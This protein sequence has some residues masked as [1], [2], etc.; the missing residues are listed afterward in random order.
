MIMSRRLLSTVLLVF[1]VT[2]PAFSANLDL[3]PLHRG[4][5][6]NFGN[7]GSRS[8]GMGGA[9]IGRADDASA[10]EANPAGLIPAISKPEFTIEVRQLDYSQSVPFGVQGSSLG[11]QT[12]QHRGTTPSFLSLAFP[13]KK[14]HMVLAAYYH[15]TLNYEQHAS[16]SAP[17]GT[18]KTI[19]GQQLFFGDA[20]GDF[21]LRYRAETL[22]LSGAWR[23]GGLSMGLGVRR[24]GV[25][26]VATDTAFDVKIVGG[27]PIKNGTTPIS[28]GRIDGSD[29]KFTYAGGLKWANP[30]ESVSLGLVYKSGADYSLTE[31]NPANASEHCN[32]KNGASPSSFEIPPQVGAGISIRPASGLTVNADVVRIQYDRLLRKF[33]PAAFCALGDCTSSPSKLGFRIPNATELHLGAEWLLPASPFALRAGWWRDPAHGLEYR[34][35][36]DNANVLTQFAQLLSAQQYQPESSQNHISVGAGYLAPTFE[37][38]AAYDHSSRSKTASVS[39]LKRF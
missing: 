35:R 8:L 34:G 36:I 31:C 15:Q 12:V 32:A 10:A 38:N 9:F 30:S 18:V 17:T 39:A 28:F 5:Q 24:E 21:S 14:I 29:S 1:L 2:L 26:A 13:V 16:L 19:S 33:T 37:I 4:L 3:T 7:P 25:R 11:S 22:G 23:V 6:F 27:A 20:P